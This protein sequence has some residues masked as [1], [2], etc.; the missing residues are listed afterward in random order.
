MTNR[1]EKMNNVI[2]TGRL[3][4]DPQLNYTANGTAIATFTVAVRRR[5]QAEGQPDADF[6]RV[7]AWGK[8]GETVAQHMK[9]G[10]MV[11]VQGRIQTRSYE[12]NEGHRVYVTEVVA[13]TVEFLDRPPQTQNGDTSPSTH[14]LDDDDLPF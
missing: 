9:K 11:G 7:V 1:S 12:N 13:E 3:T 10:R 5:V 8:L 6:I 14:D 4:A 2:L